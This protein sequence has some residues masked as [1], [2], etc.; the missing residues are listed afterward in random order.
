[1]NMYGMKRPVRMKIGIVNTNVSNWSGDDFGGEALT[2]SDNDTATRHDHEFH[3]N[4]TFDV[5]P[6]DIV[7]F[8]V[9][10]VTCDA[11]HRDEA[12]NETDCA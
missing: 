3:I 8:S 1:M 10:P 11:D 4:E 6:R 9:L 7:R 2:E 12:C 5:Y